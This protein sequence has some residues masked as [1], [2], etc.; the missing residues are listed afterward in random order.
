[1]NQYRF[2]DLAVGMEEHFSA[3]VR[4]DMM[5]AFHALSGDPNPLHLNADFARAHGFENRVVYGML[6]A[7][8]LSTLGGGYLPGELCLI[9]SVETKFLRPVFI[10]DTLTVRGVVEELHASVRRAVLKVEIRNQH[11]EKVLRGIMKVG[12][13]DEGA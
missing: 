10:G 8:L 5:D 7:S 6:T 12:V 11:G 9:Q 4:A 1:M 3:T 2:E 13:L